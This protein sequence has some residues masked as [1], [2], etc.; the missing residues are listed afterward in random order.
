MK[1]QHLFIWF[2]VVSSAI[3]GGTLALMHHNRLELP[4]DLPFLN[5][6]KTTHPTSSLQGQPNQNPSGQPSSQPF[7]QYQ[8]VAPEDSER[9]AASRQPIALRDEVPAGSAFDQFRSQFRQAV[10]DRNLAFVRGLIP[11]EGISIGFGVPRS[12]DQLDLDNP[13]SRFWGVLEKSLSRGCA[14]ARRSDYPNVDISAEVWICP[15]VVE[16]FNQQY[17]NPG[18]EPGVSYEISRVIVAGNQVNVRAQAAVN[19]AIVGVAS[20]EVVQFDRQAFEDFPPE[21]REAKLLHPTA[22]W[23]PVVLPDGQKGFVSSRYAFYPLGERLVLGQVNGDW[24]IVYIP[25]GD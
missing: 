22:G 17:P 13:N 2:V 6:S 21:Q 8:P 4:I 23:T 16:A 7:S 12:A 10:R 19:S 5:Q 1:P 11:A 3:A 20:N 9:E 25:S 24:K 18:T 15:N 14:A